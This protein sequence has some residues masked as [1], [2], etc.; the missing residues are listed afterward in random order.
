MK[1]FIAYFIVW[2]FRFAVG[3]FYT[4]VA[5]GLGF[6]VITRWDTPSV[7]T[8][9]FAVAGILVSLFSLAYVYE[10]AKRMTR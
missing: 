4:A 9:A 10:W 8:G 5:A 2:T 1:K 6:I 3:L 7:L